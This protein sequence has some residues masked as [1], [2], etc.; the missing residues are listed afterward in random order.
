MSE[1]FTEAVPVPAG[2]LAAFGLM[3]ERLEK[4]LAEAR[5]RLDAE[6]AKAVKAERDRIRGLF[7][8]WITIAMSEPNSHP[9]EAWKAAFADLISDKPQFAIGGGRE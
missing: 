5:A 7:D 6:V 3:A 4:L 2:E 1:V 9:P 8:T